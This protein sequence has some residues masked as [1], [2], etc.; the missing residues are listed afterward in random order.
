MNSWLI[1]LDPNPRIASIYAKSFHLAYVVTLAAHQL[2]TDLHVDNPSTTEAIEFQALLH[3]YI[4]APAEDVRVTPLQ[5]LSY[6]DKTEADELARATPKIETR[7]EVDVKKFTDSV[8]ENGPLAYKVTWPHGGLDVKARQFKDVVVWNPQE[9]GRKIAD[10]ERDG[11]YILSFD[12]AANAQLIGRQEALH[13][14][15]TWLCQGFCL[16]RARQDLDWPTSPYCYT[17]LIATMFL[18]IN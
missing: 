5:G 6:Y 14:R 18:C 10:M 16:S 17:R 4:R 3:T 2:S 9:E 11:W 15:G 12:F 7:S 13:L 1:V 8:Y